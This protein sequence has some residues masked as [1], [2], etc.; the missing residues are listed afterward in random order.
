MG[1]ILGYFTVM[2]YG[3]VKFRVE[4]AGRLGREKLLGVR[5]GGVL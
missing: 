1:A 5:Y 4:D 2:V 3:R